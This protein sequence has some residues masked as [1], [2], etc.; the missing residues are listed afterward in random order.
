[1][2]QHIAQLSQELGAALIK[3]RRIVATA[4]SCT[5]G[6]VA[7][8]IT[9]IS[10]SSAYFDRAFITYSNQA[11]AQMLGVDPGLI[12]R[13]GAVSE[14]VVREMAKGALAR[15]GASLSVAI[16]GVAGPTGGT[17]DKPV[18]TVWFAWAK[19][20]QVETSLMRFWGDRESIREQAVLMALQGLLARLR[21]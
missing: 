21:N 4:E 14:P 1:M 3:N 17:E 11:K 8:A 15:S 6:G 10:G 7:E 2:N 9:S 12:E 20:E 18:G 19:D 13:Y 16:S 5:G